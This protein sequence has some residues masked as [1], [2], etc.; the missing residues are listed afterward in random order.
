MKNIKI[1]LV[2]SSEAVTTDMNEVGD[3]FRQLNDMYFDSGSG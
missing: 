3:F 2:P 1:F